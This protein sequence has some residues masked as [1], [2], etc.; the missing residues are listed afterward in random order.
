MNVP[1]LLRRSRN[2]SRAIGRGG[3][4]LV[5]PRENPWSATS[6]WG[7]LAARTKSTGGNG[8]FRRSFR[9]RTVTMTLL[10]LWFAPVPQV[11]HVSPSE[12]TQAER[13]RSA[14]ATRLGLN[15]GPVTVA[16]RS[17]S[18]DST[19]LEGSFSGYRPPVPPAPGMA[20]PLHII[21]IKYDYR[22]WLRQ[23]AVRRVWTRKVGE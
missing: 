15:I 2:A 17:H 18:E 8:A 11:P 23:G 6:P 22:C 10:L 7:R 9:P 4:P 12:S 1:V 16:R 20:A 19:V 13:C 14:I 3:G 21:D 5:C